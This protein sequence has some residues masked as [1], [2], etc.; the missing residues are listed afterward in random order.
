[1]AASNGSVSRRA[2]NIGWLIHQALHLELK[3]P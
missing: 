2:E 1:M 3:N